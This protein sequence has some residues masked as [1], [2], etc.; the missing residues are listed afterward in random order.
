MPPEQKQDDCKSPSYGTKQFLV[1]CRH[2]GVHKY[3]GFLISENE[4]LTQVEFLKEILTNR[5]LPNFT[6]YS[7]VVGIGS[8][9]NTKPKPVEI[10]EVRCHRKYSS[11]HS[12]LSHYVGIII[13]G[14]KSIERILVT[15]NLFGVKA[16]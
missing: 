12:S 15:L 9:T 11:A 8:N 6:D 3:T 16:L 2:K 4:V 1:S 14:I 10:D 5:I 7:V 13:V